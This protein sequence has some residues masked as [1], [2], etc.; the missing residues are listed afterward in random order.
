MPP[1]VESS[2]IESFI[3]RADL[4]RITRLTRTTVSEVVS[5]LM[6]QGLVKEVGQAPARVGR[7]PTLLSI[8]EDARHIAAVDAYARSER[9]LQVR[10]LAG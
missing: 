9:F 10:N 1:L 5:D 3:S 2:L 6:D 4:A 8:A 7:T